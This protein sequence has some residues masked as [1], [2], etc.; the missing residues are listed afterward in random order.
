MDGWFSKSDHI[1]IVCICNTIYGYIHCIY[2]FMIVCFNYQA[3]LHSRNIIAALL[4]PRRILL[5]VVRRNHHIPV[6]GEGILQWLLQEHAILCCHRMGYVCM[7]YH[8]PVWVHT[9]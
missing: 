2:V 5:D 1:C 8:V 7:P 4:L 3:C 9:G 6:A